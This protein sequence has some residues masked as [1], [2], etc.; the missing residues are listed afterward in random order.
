MAP[1]TLKPLHDLAREDMQGIGTTAPLVSYW[2][3]LGSGLDGALLMGVQPGD[4]LFAAN[5]VNGRSGREYL[6]LSAVPMRR[7]PN[8]ERALEG[9]L[10]ERLGIELTAAGVVRVAQVRRTVGGL[11]RIQVGLVKPTG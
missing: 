2:A 4:L 5:A 3:K 7:H 6:V 11:T 10:G 1:K 8:G 9:W